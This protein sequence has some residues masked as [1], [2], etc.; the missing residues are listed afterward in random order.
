M[1]EAASGEL[2]PV[3][4]TIETGEPPDAITIVSGDNQSGQPGQALANPF[5]VEVVDANDDPVSG[6]TVN[7]SV[8]AGGGSLSR[9]SA[10]TNNNGRA[11]TTLTLGDEPG[12]NSVIARVTGITGV[13]F[14]ARSGMLVLVGASQRAP[15]YWIS[16]TEGKLYRLVDADIEPLAP[17]VTDVKGIATDEMSPLRKMVILK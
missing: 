8:T 14:T 5:V 10:T 16:R 9:S 13:T 12:E 4:F 2:S 17:N 6:V 7:F 11:Q 3:T 1:I 15:M